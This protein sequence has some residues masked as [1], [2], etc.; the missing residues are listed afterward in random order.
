M[1]N[2]VYTIMHIKCMKHTTDVFAFRH[3][4]PVIK[5][6]PKAVVQRPEMKEVFEGSFVSRMK[7]NL[8]NNTLTKVKELTL[9]NCNCLV[10]KS[11]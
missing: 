8:A 4:I 11:F 10:K 6:P 9:K 3:T 2:G 1:E 5:G 7:M